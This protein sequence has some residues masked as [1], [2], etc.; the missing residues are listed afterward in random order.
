MWRP[1]QLP[2]PSLQS[3]E[4]LIY[5]RS[6]EMSSK[7][8][9]AMS[10][11]VDS[12]VAAA[13]LLREGHQ[14][15]GVFMKNWSPETLQSLSDC[16]W[17]QDQ[18]DAAA[19]CAHLSIPFRS[20]N[21]EREYK[22]RV[23]EYFL[24]EYAAGRTPNP[25]VLCNSEIKFAAFL[26]AALA[27]GAEMIATGHYAQVEHGDIPVLRRGVDTTKDQSYFLHRLNGVQLGRALFPLGGMPKTRVRELAAEFG[28]PNARKKD[29][30]GICFIGHIDLK[31]FLHEHISGTPGEV[32]LLPAYQENVPFEQRLA[33]AELVGA[34]SGVAFAT[35]GERAGS[36]VDNK[37]Y[38][39]LRLGQEVP[40]IYL[41]EK[42]I[43]QNRL[44]VTESHDDPDFSPQWIGIGNFRLTGGTG[45]EEMG[46][47]ITP[48]LPHLS[49][50][51]RYQQRERPGIAELRQEGETV[52][53]RPNSPL[54]SP[55][56]GQF[57]VLYNA[58]RVIGGGVIGEL[59][60]EREW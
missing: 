14:V 35:L 19:A 13:L 4:E 23:V 50:Q 1:R 6:F 28:L 18:A 16:P 57:A 58:D 43:P 40:P 34:H 37:R 32:F 41:L 52:W 48:L 2:N 49:L 47:S 15:E 33:A 60:R 22:T 8:T 54:W 39:S 7:I 51:I 11:G 53:I 20:L 3:D 27:E 30:Q 59:K 55:A 29:S 42:D 25:D 26:D 36:M 21:F 17:E 46:E 45:D 44:Y 12:A 24:A 10:G 38:K 5:Q 31:K 56:P 9:V